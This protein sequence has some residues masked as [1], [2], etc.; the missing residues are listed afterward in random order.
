[1]VKVL[2]AVGSGGVGGL[3]SYAVIE[4]AMLAAGGPAFSTNP[5][6]FVLVGAL[7]GLGFFGLYRLLAS[8]LV[9]DSD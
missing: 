1:M 3:T 2:L 6:P 7:F 4:G 9:P 8:W 5:I